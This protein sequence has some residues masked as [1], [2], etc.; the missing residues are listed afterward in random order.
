MFHVSV[1]DADGKAIPDAEVTVTLVMP[2]MPSM[3]MPEMRN[4]FQA[5]ICAGNVHGQGQHRNGWFVERIG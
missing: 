4:S 3:G 5:A 2:A 1:L